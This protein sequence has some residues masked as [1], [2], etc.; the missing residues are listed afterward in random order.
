MSFESACLS[1]SLPFCDDKAKGCKFR[2]KTKQSKIQKAKFRKIN[3]REAVQIREGILMM[4]LQ[5][6]RENE[7]KNSK[8]KAL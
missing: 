3:E 6:K 8:S 4:L 1:C 2:I 7:A 5:L